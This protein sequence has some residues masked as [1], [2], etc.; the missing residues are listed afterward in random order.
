M[1][2]KV[3][4]TIAGTMGTMSDISML[5]NIKSFGIEVVTAD[6]ADKDSSVSVLA[7]KKYVVPKVKDTKYIN[8]LIDICKGEKITTIIPQY[9]DELLP[10]SENLG[11]FRDIGVEILVTEDIERLKIANNKVSLY[12]FFK[13]RAFVPK[14]AIASETASIKA[15]ALELGYPDIPI[16][17]KP[18][19]GEGGKGFRILTEEKFDIFN[20]PDSSIKMTLAAYIDRLE[21]MDRI[22]E[23]LI[24]E[25]LPGKE[26]SVD[27]VCKNGKPFVSIPRQR[28]ETSMG[29]A[30]VSLVEKNE[31]LINYSNEIISSLNL[32]YNINIQFKYSADGAPKLL[33]INPR[34]SG[35]LV[36][37]YG[38]G[39]NMLE[40]SLK[41][42]YGIPVEKPDIKWGTKM[43][44]HWDQTFIQI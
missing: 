19:S 5:K 25:Y 16:C 36:A 33:E 28:I 21:K 20:E 43:I 8:K 39:I 27:C 10:L 41:L 38:A 1:D 7:G 31:E 6:T 17:I 14:Y 4:W 23:L 30:T 24:T 26:Y 40:S 34:V 13:G 15:A 12:H 44:R 37:N 18:A 29:I 32:S 2:L 22:P 11:L 35:S 42:A 3:L 9:T